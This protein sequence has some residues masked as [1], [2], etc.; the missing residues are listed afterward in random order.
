MYKI[1]FNGKNLNQVAPYQ[2]RWS[3]KWIVYKIKRAIRWTIKWTAITAS[4]SAILIGAGAYGIWAY[5]RTVEAEPIK[6]EVTKRLAIQD[7]IAGC[8]SEGNAKSKGSQFNTKGVMRKHVNKD[9][10]VD[11]GK[12]MINDYHWEAKAVEMGFNIYT[13][14]GNDKMAEWIF[15]Q[16]GS[17]PW[18][19]S[20]KCWSK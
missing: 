19:A 5:P 4:I 1:L 11:I 3:I 6:V 7:K 20:V 18:S 8:E 13:E 9:G 16:Y 17:S 15:S 12:N 14:E 10:T 2:K